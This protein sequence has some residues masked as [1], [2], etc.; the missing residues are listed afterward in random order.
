[1]KKIL[2]LFS[3]LLLLSACTDNSSVRDVYD[4][5]SLNI[6]YLG[7]KPD[8]E[9]EDV[10]FEEIQIN[11]IDP[12]KYKE[13]A[14]YLSEEYD[15]LW[16]TPSMFDELSDDQYATFFRELNIPTAFIDSNKRHY[17]FVTKDLSY[18]TSFDL[19]NGS[20]STLYLNYGGVDDREEAWFFYLNNSNGN[21]KDLKE[22]YKEILYQIEDI[23]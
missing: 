4:G 22:V 14:K 6:G 18:D 5:K 9:V 13:N 3:V 8:F 20:H 16:V 10:K 19:D 17:P 15:A 1:M 11:E 7:D 12:N 23:S 21:K 2:I